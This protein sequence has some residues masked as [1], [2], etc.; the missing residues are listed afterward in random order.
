MKT[1][2]K[3]FRIIATKFHHI[4]DNVFLVTDADE[5][6]I[7]DDDDEFITDESEY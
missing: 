7:T 6:Y 3:Y 1:I 5:D 2:N 4:I